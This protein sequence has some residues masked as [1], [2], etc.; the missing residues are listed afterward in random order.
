MARSRNLK[1]GFF[2][3]AELAECSAWARL[4][5]A[6]LWTLAD[7]EGRLLDRPKRIKGE[8]FAYDSVEVDEL[9]DELA[10]KDFILRY[11]TPEGVRIIQILQFRKHQNPHFKE[12]KSELPSPESLGLVI[13]HK[14]DTDQKPRTSPPL[15]DTRS[16]TSPG[17]DPPL[18]ETQ[19]SGEPEASTRQAP[20]EPETSP[21]PAPDPGLVERGSNRAD[22]LLLIPDSLNPL[23]THTHPPPGVTR[24]GSVCRALRRAG[25]AGVN[26]AHPG[27]QQLLEAG[28]DEAEFVAAAEKAA[29]K[30]DPFAYVLGVVEGQRRHAKAMAE[31]VHHGPLPSTESPRER[32]ARKRV[33]AAVPSLAPRPVAAEGTTPP[34]SM[35]VVDVPARRLG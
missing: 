16:E 20:G 15:N 29:D 35:E 4:C 12:P 22:S 11:S 28:A 21:S 13:Q 7:R 30:R 10:A 32:E 17:L 19:V 14:D 33:E 3:N 1:P 23:P 27:L 9:L 5:F 31:G 8:L 18:N 2:K 26:P 25:V 34:S 6:G 24:A